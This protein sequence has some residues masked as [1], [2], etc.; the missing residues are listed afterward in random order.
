MR[1]RFDTWVGKIP[2]EKRMTTQASILTWRIPCTE[3]PGGLQTMGLQLDITEW[4]THSQVCLLFCLHEDITGALGG[5]NTISM[6]PHDILKQEKNCFWPQLSWELVQFVF[7]NLHFSCGD[8]DIYKNI[9]MLNLFKYVFSF[10]SQNLRT[11]YSYRLG[12]NYSS[13]TII[14][15]SCWM[16]IAFFSNVLRNLFSS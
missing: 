14:A 7:S 15:I 6:W 1:P 3:E 12:V 10:N 13:E 16:H 4:S 11:T 2:L 9:T 5:K 8:T